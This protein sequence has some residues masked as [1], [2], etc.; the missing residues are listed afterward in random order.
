VGGFSTE[1]R[2]QDHF[3]LEVLYKSASRLVDD[4]RDRWNIKNLTTGSIGITGISKIEGE[5]WLA[6]KW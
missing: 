1:V 5:A 3:A 2:N 6:Q 4:Y